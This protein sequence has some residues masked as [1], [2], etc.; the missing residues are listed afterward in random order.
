MDLGGATPLAAFIAGVISILSPCVLPLLPVIFAYST[1]KGKLRPLAI[2]SGLSL[3][4]VFMGIITSVFGSLFQQYL[5]YLTAFAGI[6]V[7]LMGLTLLFDLGTFNSIGGLSG[8]QFKENGLMGG[9]LLGISLGIIWIPCVGPILASI[10]SLVAIEGDLLYGA[11]LLFVYSMG[12]GIPMLLIAYS[13]NISSSKLG[14]IAKYDM[15]L[16][17]VVGF[18]LVLVGMWMLYNNVLIRL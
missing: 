18:I 11:F 17:K 15:Y 3:S 4:F 7:I 5:I 2:V 16:K 12:L 13:A 9:L 10:L 1:S 8:K 6:I 14:M